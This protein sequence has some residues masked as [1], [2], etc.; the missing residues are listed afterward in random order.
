MVVDVE[1]RTV[2]VA[3]RTALSSSSFIVPSATHCAA[4]RTSQLKVTAT[5]LRPTYTTMCLEAAG[6]EG[7]FISFVLS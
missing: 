2:G 1:E 6:S 4:F 7:A 3:G 5:R